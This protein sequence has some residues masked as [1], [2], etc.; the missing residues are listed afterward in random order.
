LCRLSA[1]WGQPETGM[2]DRQGQVSDE[3]SLRHS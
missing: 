1:A 3:H 2:G